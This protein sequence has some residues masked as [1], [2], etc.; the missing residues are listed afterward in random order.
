VFEEPAPVGAGF[1][2][3]VFGVE[4]PG[5][6]LSEAFSK[7]MGRKKL[8]WWE[9]P[10]LGHAFYKFDG[11]K[12]A[13]LVGEPHPRTCLIRIRWSEKRILSIQIRICCCE[14]G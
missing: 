2:V 14:D 1:F 6:I 8:V 13:C 5:P 9:Y 3:L 4:E 10:I 7:P 12:K 11:V